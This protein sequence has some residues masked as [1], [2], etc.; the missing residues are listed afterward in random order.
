MIDGLEDEYGPIP[1]RE[2]ILAEDLAA[3]IGPEIERRRRR[4]EAEE[5]LT[6]RP[7]TSKGEGPIGPLQQLEHETGLAER[8]IFRILKG[9][10]CWVDLTIAD[11]ICLA[12]GLNITEA[13]PSEAF[14]PASE[15]H[16]AVKMQTEMLFQ[17]A[18]RRG[19]VVP[20]VGTSARRS[21]PGKYRRQLFREAA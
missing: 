16:D 14:R 13:L 1:E 6:T 11:D 8:A 21:F 17:N 7:R 9:E 12:L 5:R 2:V 20:P 4:F 10:A 18:Q 3:V 19:L 15:V